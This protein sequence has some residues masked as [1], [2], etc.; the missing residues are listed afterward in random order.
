[1]I[2]ETTRITFQFDSLLAESQIDLLCELMDKYI[3]EDYVMS[4]QIVEVEE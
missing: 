1:M 4:G 2:R 3:S